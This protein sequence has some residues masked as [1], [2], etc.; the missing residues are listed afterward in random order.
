MFDLDKQDLYNI[1]IN[2]RHP[3]HKLGDKICQ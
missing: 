2:E 3:R 1:N